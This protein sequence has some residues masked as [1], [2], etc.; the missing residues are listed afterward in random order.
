MYFQGYYL[1]TCFL[2]FPSCDLRCLK[3]VCSVSFFHI[4]EMELLLFFK[5]Y[6]QTFP[7]LSTFFM[8]RNERED[9][10]SHHGCCRSLKS[11]HRLY[12]KISGKIMIGFFFVSCID[13]IQFALIPCADK[14]RLEEMTKRF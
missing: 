1:N 8:K 6:A 11:V 3:H 2:P 7:S 14:S 13:I 5:T 12:M 10:T 4:S 9:S